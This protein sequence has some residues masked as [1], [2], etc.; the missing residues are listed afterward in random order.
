MDRLF[1]INDT[2]GD[3]EASL[4]T[5]FLAPC[6]QDRYELTILRD[7]SDRR[8]IISGRTGTGK[9]ALLQKFLQA[10]QAE[11]RTAEINPHDVALRYLS[12]N[13]I[14]NYFRNAGINI[15]FAYPVLWLHVLMLELLNLY[16]GPNKVNKKRA[17]FD[18]I[19]YRLSRKNIHLEALEYV[20]TY[21]A[22]R[23]NMFW[24]TSEERNPTR[25]T[26]EDIRN[27]INASIGADKVAKAVLGAKNT[28]G[29]SLEEEVEIFVR[30]YAIIEED[31]CKELT[32]V[33][34]ALNTILDKKDKQYFIV[35]DHLNEN[36][37]KDD[38]ER[39]R[40]IQA[41]LVTVNKFNS[42]VRN[43]KVIVP[44]QTSLLDYVIEL[45][46]DTIPGFQREKFIGPLRIV[47][48][49]GSL[50]ELL[51]K[52]L[53]WQ[54]PNEHYTSSD[55][56]TGTIDGQKPI[57]YL[58]DRTLQ[59][60][61]DAIDFFNKCISRAALAHQDK[62]APNHLRAAERNY[63]EM[64]RK[65]LQDEWSISYPHL[66]QIFE[67]LREKPSSF[68]LGEISEPQLERLSLEVV[69]RK[70]SPD[71]GKDFNEIK[72]YRDRHK[73]AQELRAFLASILYRV[74][75]I[76]L[77]QQVERPDGSTEAE[78]QWSYFG[79]LEENLPA[80][81]NDDTTIQ[82]HKMLWLALEIKPGPVAQHVQ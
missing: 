50:K 2:I 39:Y 65:A 53:G 26:I 29:F 38:Q 27:E 73:T 63:S 68:K 69:V 1:R 45:A 10:E 72:A 47:W 66:D 64:R 60:P 79:D 54:Y 55:L 13:T 22:S 21:R 59:R 17:G 49:P 62:I 36:W 80:E 12:N 6:F 82:V 31:L 48:E 78:I 32:R 9:T 57:D 77:E 15:D 3:L 18:K 71:K 37:V 56:L 81:V 40:L 74:G 35:V 23:D 11:K 20:R 51:D 28:A 44:L 25:K 41:L 8:G 58:L 75:A 42:Q 46:A 24:V 5:K 16:F 30:A 7:S 14:L 34:Y 4:D 61:R 43:A 33:F 76:G 19:V 67:I 52:R 70:A